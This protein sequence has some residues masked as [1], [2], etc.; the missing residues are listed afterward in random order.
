MGGVRVSFEDVVGHLLDEV[1][2]DGKQVLHK[3]AICLLN[4][5]ELNRHILRQLRK[6]KQ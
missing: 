4:L 5:A 1:L 6:V 2:Q 3:F